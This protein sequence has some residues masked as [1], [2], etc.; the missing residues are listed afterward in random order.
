ME[1]IA[2]PDAAT[3]LWA[4]HIF[5]SFWVPNAALNDQ[6]FMQ[7]IAAP[8]SNNHDVVWFPVLPFILGLTFSPGAKISYS[9]LQVISEARH[10][11]KISWVSTDLLPISGV[12][13]FVS[14]EIGDID[15]WVI[16]SSVYCFGQYFLPLLSVQGWLSWI[17]VLHSSCQWLNCL[18]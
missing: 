5:L 10:R 16:S 1:F 6:L 11:F 4:F 17:R 15:P 8:V 14:A 9:L 13:Y 2:S 18:Q 12:M 7:V 3:Q